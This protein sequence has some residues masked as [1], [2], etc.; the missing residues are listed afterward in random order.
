MLDDREEAEQ[1]SVYIK[2]RRDLARRW[3]SHQIEEFHADGFVD[4]RGIF[5]V[6]LEKKKVDA[7]KCLCLLVVGDIY[8][9]I[10]FHRT[11]RSS[12]VIANSDVER[13]AV[14]GKLRVIV[15]IGRINLEHCRPVVWIDRQKDLLNDTVI[16]KGVRCRLGANER[17]ESR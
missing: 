16:E 17:A 2:L 14:P 11:A 4:V 12:S 1:L 8:V 5:V 9:D 13:S 6:R 10:G 3:N 7:L 15:G